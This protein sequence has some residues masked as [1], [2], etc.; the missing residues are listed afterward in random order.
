MQKIPIDLAR[1]GMKLARPVERENGITVMAADMELTQPLIDRIQSMNIDRI[2]VH[3]HPVDMGGAM[4]GTKFDERLKRMPHL[5]RVY[6][7]DKW[8]MMVQKRLES[9][10]RIKAAAQAA[11]AKALLREGQ[12][13]LEIEQAQ[14]NGNGGE[15]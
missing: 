5:F 9:Y 11:R 6:K 1:P 2:I 14:V 13:D 12:S 7:K 4:G 8:M 3:G 15:A 10:F